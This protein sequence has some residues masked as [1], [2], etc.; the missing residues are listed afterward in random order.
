MLRHCF[1]F[2]LARYTQPG[3]PD[4]V[5]SGM[6]LDAAAGTW[7]VTLAQSCRDAPGTG[8]RALPFHI[9]VAVGLLDAATGAEVLP[10]E[11]LELTEAAQTFT[12]KLPAAA[13]PSAVVPSL[14]RGFR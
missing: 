8:A 2:P 10:T 11:T 6:V 7:T 3:T 5:A 4:V 12:Q 14:L 13:N 9:P 1:P